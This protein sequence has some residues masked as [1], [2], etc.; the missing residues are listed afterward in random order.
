MSVRITCIKKDGGNHEN[1]H[2]AI[3]ILGWVNESAGASG[4]STRVQMYDFV[5]GGGQA[6]VRDSRSN[7]AYLIAEVSSRGTKFVKTKPD[8]TTTDNLLKLIEC[9]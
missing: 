2:T 3:S 6:Y 9:S 5:K 4:Q 1:P 8:G 7:L